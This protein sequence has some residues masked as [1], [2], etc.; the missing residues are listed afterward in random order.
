EDFYGAGHLV[1]HFTRRQPGWELTDTALAAAILHDGSE[2]LA[3]L[4]RSRVGRMMRERGLEREVEWAAR[5][6]HL[7]VVPELRGTS[8]IN[9][10]A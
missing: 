10:A 5:K 1:S 6:D 2:A 7:A 9:A 8:L 4:S 3:C